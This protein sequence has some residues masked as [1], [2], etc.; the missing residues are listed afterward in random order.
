[1]KK[2]ESKFK[3]WDGTP[4]DT[5]GREPHTCPFTEELHDKYPE[6]TKGALCN[7]CKEC[8]QAC[9]YEI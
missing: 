9:E 7:C 2:C 3:K 4:C 8:T 6:L 5:D 1:M